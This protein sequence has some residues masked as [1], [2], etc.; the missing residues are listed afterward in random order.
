M[1]PGGPGCW[2]CD[3]TTM[4]WLPHLQCLVREQLTCD[5]YIVS[6]VTILF[7]LF[8]S[9]LT[10]RIRSGVWWHT[11]VSPGLERERQEGCSKF[12]AMLSQIIAFVSVYFDMASHVAQALFELL[13]LLHVEGITD[14]VRN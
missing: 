1:G 3:L 10:S 4:Q 9:H 14:Q 12:Q 11:H 5:P 7:W 13:P 6:I 2:V 8:C